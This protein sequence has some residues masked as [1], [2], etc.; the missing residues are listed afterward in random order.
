MYQTCRVTMS[1]FKKNISSFK[2]LLAGAFVFC[3]ASSVR[4]LE[5]MRAAVSFSDFEGKYLGRMVTDLTY[6]P[7]FILAGLATVKVL[8]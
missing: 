3:K 5:A 8:G 1:C 2:G 6:P 7:F 4:N